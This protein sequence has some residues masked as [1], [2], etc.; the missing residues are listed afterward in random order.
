MYIIKHLSGEFTT[1]LQGQMW[2]IK[3]EWKKRGSM[4]SQVSAKGSNL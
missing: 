4:L 1:Y 3:E 2:K